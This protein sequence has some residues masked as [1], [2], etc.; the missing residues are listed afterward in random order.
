[1]DEQLTYEEQAERRRRAE[2]NEARDAVRALSHFVNRMGHSQ[3]LLIEELAR[4][5][6]TL[7]QSITETMLRW[8]AHLAMLKE[9]EYDDR[10]KASVQMARQ[11]ASMMEAKYGTGWYRLPFI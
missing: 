6:R 2:A 5:H 4:E 11:I 8:F 9:Y 1:M 7:Q 10:N 3:S